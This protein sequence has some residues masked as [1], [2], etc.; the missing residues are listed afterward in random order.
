[1]TLTHNTLSQALNVGSTGKK[2]GRRWTDGPTDRKESKSTVARVKD[3]VG[4]TT[5]KQRAKPNAATQ[6]GVA[7]RTR[8]SC[9][10]KD[11]PLQLPTTERTEQTEPRRTFADVVAGRNAAGPKTTSMVAKVS[12]SVQIKRGLYVPVRVSG[13]KS[14]G[15]IRALIDTGSNLNLLPIAVVNDFLTLN[16]TVINLI[17][18]D[19][20]RIRT[21]GEVSVVISL[22]GLRRDFSANFVVADV[23]NPILGLKFLAEHGL[24]IN[25]AG[26]YIQDE[27]TGRK[28]QAVEPEKEILPITVSNIEDIAGLNP[29]VKELLQKYNEITGERDPHFKKRTSKVVHYIDTGDNRPVYSKARP[30]DAEK[31][32]YV[33]AEF[34]ALLRDGV[35]EPSKSEWSS[36]LVLVPKPTKKK[37][38]Y[39]IVG[40]YR[41]LNAISSPDRYPVPFISSM[42]HGLKGKKV[43]SKVDLTQAYHYIPVNEADIPKTA[44]ITG[45]GLF[46]L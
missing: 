16:P 36:P 11:S 8:A 6:V 45:F 7:V 9:V 2:K 33:R 13:N 25:C 5:G 21:Y 41:R 37:K 29:Q 26:K 18:A 40:D 3:A 38:K 44:V 34:E 10:T 42:T 27:A 43:F 19:G 20:S 24:S 30:L 35:I 23:L 1:M 31:E 15:A 4:R 32:K 46:Q 22:P 14:N 17:N 12:E 28:C 39:R